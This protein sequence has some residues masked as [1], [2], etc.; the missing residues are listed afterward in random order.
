MGFLVSSHSMGQRVSLEAELPIG[1]L[2][3]EPHP[4]LLS[5]SW[6]A[7]SSVVSAI[8][9]CVFRSLELPLT[10][11]KRKY[12]SQQPSQKPDHT[13]TQWVRTTSSGRSEWSLKA[14]EISSWEVWFS[15][16]PQAV[17]EYRDLWAIWTE[18]VFLSATDTIWDCLAADP[19]T[20]KSTATLKA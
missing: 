8:Q 5:S 12:M 14:R 1:L 15:C 3:L 10:P 17:G 7:S 6:S 4:D 18:Q 9:K 16:Q 2:L 11:Q 20:L 13:W 19:C